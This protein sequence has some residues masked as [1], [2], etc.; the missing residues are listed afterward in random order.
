MMAARPDADP[1]RI[2]LMGVSAGGWGSLAAASQ[3]L[4]GLVGV[5]NF[6]GGRGS[7]GPDEVC[8]PD[9]LVA[10]AARYGRG[11]RVPELWIYSVNDRFFGPELA[12]RLHRAF[13]E[14]GG[15]ARFVAAPAYGAD[16]HRYIRAAESWAQEVDA[17]FGQ[18]GFLAP[19]R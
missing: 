18:I 9:E 13:T 7:R 14:A 15:Q 16:G 11:S 6:A 10:A 8:K 4:K 1:G 3:P 19:K 12:R 17:F 5:V 2:V